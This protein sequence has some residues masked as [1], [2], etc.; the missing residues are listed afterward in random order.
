MTFSVYEQFKVL[1]IDVMH[2]IEWEYS[3]ISSL[4]LDF[5][6]SAKIS[7]FILKNKY[8]KRKV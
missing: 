1:I 2:Q 5:K 7:V 4:I 6:S 3:G 8:L